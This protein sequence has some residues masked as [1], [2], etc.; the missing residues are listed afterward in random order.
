MK[1]ALFGL[2]FALL[3]LMVVVSVALAAETVVVYPG[4][5][6]GWVF[7][8]TLNGLGGLVE[9]PDNPPLGRG[10]AQLVI[11]GYTQAYGGLRLG[12]ITNS[13]YST[14]QKGVVMIS[15]PS[16]QLEVDYDLED[17]NNNYQGWLIY[18]PRGGVV[19]PFVWQAWNPLAGTWRATYF[20]GTT[21]CSWANPCSWEQLLDKFK[22]IGVRVGGKVKFVAGS[23]ITNNT[24]GGG[25][26]IDAFTMGIEEE[27]VTY[28]FE[29]TPP[30]KADVLT[31]SGVSGK[32]L[33]KAP[34]L[35]KNFNDRSQGEENAGKK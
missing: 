27:D 7:Y 28:D 33:E 5:M 35:E 16:L 10:S 6:H 4:E 18:E 11:D 3:L 9:G 29:A 26:Y 25:S 19:Q 15:A 30:T 12:R 20:P 1:K 13:V 8:R 34:G 31:N 22:N 21:I 24:I 23:Y 17:T 2:I 14:Y 32:G